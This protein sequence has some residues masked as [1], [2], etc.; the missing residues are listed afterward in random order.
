MCSGIETLKL[1]LSTYP[2]RRLVKSTVRTESE[3]SQ[4]PS[5]RRQRSLWVCAYWEGFLLS[6]D[7]KTACRPDKVAENGINMC[8]ALGFT[9]LQA[10]AKCVRRMLRRPGRKLADDNN[11]ERLWI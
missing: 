4:C 11:F 1:R 10:I 5:L 8:F 2:Q 6:K 3:T 9:I 7:P